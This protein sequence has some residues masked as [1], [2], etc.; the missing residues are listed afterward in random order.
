MAQ[1]LSPYPRNPIH[2]YCQN[3]FDVSEYLS[4]G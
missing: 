4:G 2:N 3:L 1:R